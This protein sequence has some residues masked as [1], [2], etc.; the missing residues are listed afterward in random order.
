MARK[1]FTWVMSVLT[2]S[3]DLTMSLF[4]GAGLTARVTQ[5]AEEKQTIVNLVAAGT[6]LAIAPRWTAQP[7]GLSGRCDRSHSAVQR[8]LEV[9]RRGPSNQL[10][11]ANAKSWAG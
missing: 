2:H 3:H 4:L 9:L 11:A 6:G 10:F 1:Y 5:N 7:P 8:L